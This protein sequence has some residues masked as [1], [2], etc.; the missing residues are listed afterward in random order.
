MEKHLLTAGRPDKTKTIAPVGIPFDRSSS[1]RVGKMRE[2]AQEIKGLHSA[3][4]YGPQ[5]QTIFLGWDE[6]AVR[7]AAF[8][9]GDKEAAETRAAEKQRVEGRDKQHQKYLEFLKGKGRQMTCSPAGRYIVDCDEIEKEDDVK[10]LTLDINETDHDGIFSVG[11]NF[12][13]LEGVMLICADKGKLDEYASRLDADEES[14]EGDTD[15]FDSSD[16]EDMEDDNESRV[17]EMSGE[18]NLGSGMRG[19][20]RKSQASAP[21]REPGKKARTASAQPLQYFIKFRCRETGEGQL[22]PEAEEGTLRFK[23]KR[24][25]AFS[26]KVDMAVWA[27]R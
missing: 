24:M 18:S 11:F 17:D 13:I 25:A 21:R 3:T 6:E 7:Q 8:D 19:R 14:D 20:K 27:P 15:E 12:G 26:G 4:G 9:H 1:Y 10:D 2:A 23:D 5:T 16:E 22:Y